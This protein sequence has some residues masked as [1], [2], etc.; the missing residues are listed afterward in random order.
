M[1]SASRE[2][3]E[4]T[5]SVIVQPFLDSLDFTTTVYCLTEITNKL[6]EVLNLGLDNRRTKS[7]LV[8]YYGQQITFSYPQ[9]R[10]LP[11]VV[12]G[13][14]IGVSDIIETRLRKSD[15]IKESAS[16]LKSEMGPEIERFDFRLQNTLCLASDLSFSIQTFKDKKITVQPN[17]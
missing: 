5:P 1:Y 9:D 13:C 17:G 10:S 12:F 2:T 7:I 6:N 14:S 16:I 4:V 11:Q 15:P 8:K 3:G